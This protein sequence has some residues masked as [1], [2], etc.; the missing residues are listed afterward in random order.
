MEVMFTPWRSAYMAGGGVDPKLGCLLCQLHRLSDSDALIVHRGPTCYVLLNR[1]PYTNGHLMVTPYEHR[2]SLSSMD[3]VERRELVELAATCEAILLAE[4][5]PHGFNHGLNI[6]R[7]AG[8]GVA[9]HAHL[10]VIPRWDGDTNFFL[11]IGGT[12]TVPEDLG[13]THTRLAARFAAV[14]PPKGPGEP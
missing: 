8:A 5:G 6:G 14:L 3:V 1:Y 10:H 12:R 2:G 11:T 9:D 7:S 4:Y 13:I